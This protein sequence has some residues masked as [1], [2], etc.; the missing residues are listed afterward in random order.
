MIDFIFFVLGFCILA[1]LLIP[2]PDPSEMIS[3]RSENDEKK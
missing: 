1:G 2:D 3:F